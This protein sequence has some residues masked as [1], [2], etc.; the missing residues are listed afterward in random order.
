M[1]WR[2]LDCN[3]TR[4]IQQDWYALPEQTRHYRVYA[5]NARAQA[6]SGR[7]HSRPPSRADSPPA[8]MKRTLDEVRDAVA[9]RV[10]RPRS[11]HEGGHV[12]VVLLKESALRYGSADP[13]AVHGR[14][15]TSGPL[16]RGCCS[17]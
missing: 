10:T 7:R 13:G 3:A 17:R 8:S 15:A 11:L 5:S 12:Y 2:C 6:S 14:C 9:A 16:R 4:R 1:E